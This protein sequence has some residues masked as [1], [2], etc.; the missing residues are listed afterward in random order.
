MAKQKGEPKIALQI[1]M[2]PSL[3]LDGL[4]HYES[5]QRLGS[6]EFL[7]SKRSIEDIRT[8]YLTRPEEALNPLVSPILALDLAGLPPALIVTA[9]FDPL[10]DEAD[11][12]ARRLRGAGVPATYRCYEGTIHSFMIMAGIINL[13][14]SAL[15]LVASQIRSL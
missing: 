15:D 12:Y 14:Y 5:W 11:H 1:P 10:V 9:E 2:C 6:G 4:E 13:G 7:L 8:L 3:T